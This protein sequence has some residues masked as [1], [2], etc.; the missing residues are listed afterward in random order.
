MNRSGYNDDC[1]DAA[2]NVWRGAVASA[3]RGKRGQAFLHELLT[4]LDAMPEKRLAAEALRDDEGTV[5]ALG[6]VGHAR[7]LDLAAIDPEDRTAVA[8]AF[9]IAEA[10]AAEIMWEN[11]MGYRWSDGAYGDN[12]R[13][14]YMRD[15]AQRHLAERAT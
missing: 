12:R 10:M 5:C 13:W 11:D 1:D 14:A 6:V 9:G 8:G 3:I 4:A 15:W 2:C 7:G